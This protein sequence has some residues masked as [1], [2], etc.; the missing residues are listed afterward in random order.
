MT[1]P[2]YRGMDRAALDVAYNNV[3]D[4]PDYQAIMGRFKAQSEVVY[5]SVEVKRD[6]PYGGRPRQRFDW[7]SCGKEAAPT[8]V[9]IHGGYWQ[10][11]AKDDLA[12]I[13]RGPLERGFNV[14]LAEY[15]LA[16]EASMTE[17]V[18]EI[19][20]LLKFLQ[21]DTSDA[22]FGGRPVCVC[23][24]SAGGQLAALYR[25]HPGIT[26][27]VCVSALFDLEPISLS[28]LNDKLQLTEQE[29]SRFSPL[30][31]I[32]RG[33]P[34]VV[35]V[36]MAELPELI[37]QSRSYASACEAR[38]ESVAFLPIPERRHFTILTDLADPAG[39]HMAA[40]V[41]RVI[42]SPR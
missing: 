4:E 17:I 27:T 22:G 12:F 6:I 8:F 1:N 3:R 38:G 23:G 18:S 39:A 13:A 16:P 28:W 29:I 41:E 5:R 42:P 35:S 7:L 2:V 36:G 30:H 34:T 15:T 20:L 32:D 26:L 37:R 33:A 10:N 24:H 31:Q 11:Y 14:V 25:N 9:F 21:S 19:G 40:I